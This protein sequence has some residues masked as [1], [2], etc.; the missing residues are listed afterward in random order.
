MIYSRSITIEDR[1]ALEQFYHKAYPQRKD[2]KDYLGRTLFALPLSKI[3]DSLIIFDDQKVIGVNLCLS[4]RAMIGTDEHDIVWSYDTLVLPEYRDTDAGTFIAE[5]W[6]KNRHIFGAG[7]S[8]I[9]EKM[10]KVMKSKFIAY[11]TAF[12][13]FNFTSRY[14]LNFLKPVFSVDSIFQKKFPDTIT[15]KHAKFEKLKSPDDFQSDSEGYWNTNIIEFK[16]D[17]EFIAWRFFQPDSKYIL[18]QDKKTNDYF[19]VRIIIWHNMPLLYLVDYRFRLDKIEVFDEIIDGAFHLVKKL[20]CAGLYIRS[21]LD[22]IK[23]VCEKRHFIKKGQGAQ[24]VTR[25]KPAVKT[26]YPFFFTPADSDMD[27]K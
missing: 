13:K 9:S 12:L 7:L 25:F 11:A 4:A 1:K 19:A 23:D 20:N 10:C 16:R 15:V 14:L 26:D 3:K 18:Y 2:I 17:S 21:S 5:F 27:F 24:I 22:A 8:E 6:F